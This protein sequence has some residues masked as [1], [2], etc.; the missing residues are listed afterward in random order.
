V[1]GKIPKIREVEYEEA[2]NFANEKGYQYFE[3]NIS[4]GKN[5][6]ELI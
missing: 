5:T 2:L 1:L 3:C 4:Q 6:V